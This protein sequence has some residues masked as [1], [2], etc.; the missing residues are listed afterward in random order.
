MQSTPFFF[1]YCWLDC[2]VVKTFGKFPVLKLPQIL[3]SKALT[4]FSP[5]SRDVRGHTGKRAAA[6]SC[7]RLGSLLTDTAVYSRWPPHTRDALHN[8]AVGTLD[9]NLSKDF[10]YVNLPSTLRHKIKYRS[11]WKMLHTL[12]PRTPS[13]PELGSKPYFLPRF[14]LKLKVH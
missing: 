13:L 1:F 7:E 14:G 5:F 4:E 2:S 10:F 6:C 8:W 12:R 3:S 9:L 11:T